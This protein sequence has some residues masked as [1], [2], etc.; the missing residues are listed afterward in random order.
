[1]RS[2]LLVLS[3]LLVAGAAHAQAAAE[4]PPLKIGYVDMARALN[5]VDDGK[6]AKARLKSDFDEKQK[7]LDKMQAD[8]KA[9]KDEFEKKASM[10]NPDYKQQKQEELQRS[11]LELQR[12]Y[13]ELQKEL[14]DKEAQVTNEIG[15]K[16]RRVIDSI[17]DR[18]GYNVILNLGDTVLYYKRHLDITD[19]VVREYN[20]QYTSKK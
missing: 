14:T 4:K 5:D 17:G 18:D 16:L 15:N 9:K 2:P 6:T 7:K 10:M 13:M 20:R 8:L 11:F 3:L 1:M 19:E 12:T